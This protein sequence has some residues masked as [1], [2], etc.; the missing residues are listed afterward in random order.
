MKILGWDVRPLMAA[1]GF[2][3]IV[4][5]LATQSVLANALAGLQL[6][7]CTVPRTH[8]FRAGKEQLPA[9]FQCQNS[10]VYMPSCW[11]LSDRMRLAHLQPSTACTV[12]CMSHLTAYDLSSRAM[13]LGESHVRHCPSCKQCRPELQQI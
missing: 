6:V 12:I 8:L 11:H 7:T 13:P 3:G 9:S 4:L 5:G 2:S 10:C 1:G